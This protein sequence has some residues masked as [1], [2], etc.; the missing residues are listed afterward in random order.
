MSSVSQKTF[1]DAMKALGKKLDLIINQQKEFAV[2]LSSISDEVQT[3]KN[4]SKSRDAKIASL[5]SQL[6]EQKSKFDTIETKLLEIEVK[7]RKLNLIIFG[8]PKEKNQQSVLTN[9]STLLT[10][11]MEITDKIRLS[12]CYRVPQKSNVSSRK[13][14]TPPVFVTVSTEK[15]I[16]S[17]FSS[18]SKLKGT[19]VRICTDLPPKLN[20][21]RNELLSKGKEMRENGSAQLR[22]VTQK[23]A[24][25]WLEYKSDSESQWAKA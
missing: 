11:K 6:E 10:S 3:L 2:T 14:Y 18:I 7:D 19:G 5:E 17:I 23:G 13:P 1:D 15:D 21:I 9:V 22:Q 8:L 25:L 4:E 20:S 12:Q 16:L 24:K